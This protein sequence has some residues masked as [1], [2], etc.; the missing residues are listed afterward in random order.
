MG[1]PAKMGLAFLAS[2]SIAALGAWELRKPNLSFVERIDRACRDE[3]GSDGDIAIGQCKIALVGRVLGDRK[4][5]RLQ[6]AFDRV[7]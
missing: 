5:A 3:F 6:A 2:A 7:Q 1:L 4:D